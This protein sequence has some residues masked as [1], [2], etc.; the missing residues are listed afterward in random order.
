MI[1]HFEKKK[2]EK[3]L[4]SVNCNPTSSTNF[5][6]LLY[7]S[8]KKPMAKII[9]QRNSRKKYYQGRGQV[10][11]KMLSRKTRKK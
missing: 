4:D 5:P 1:L 6:I 10:V 11:L 2:Q 3:C 8:K 7:R 9:N